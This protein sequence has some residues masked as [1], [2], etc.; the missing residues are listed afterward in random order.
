MA[1]ITL[2]NNSLSSVTALPAGVGGKVLQVVST[3]KT[4]TF[5]TTLASGA[6]TAITGLSASITPSS[7]SNKILIMVTL[8]VGGSGNVG[9]TFLLKRASTDILV[10]DT[11]GSRKRATFSSGKNITGYE[12]TVSAS[13]TG[14]DSPSTTSSTTYSVSI[15]NSRGESDSF[16]INRGSSDTDNS[17]QQR[18]ASTITL[19]EIAG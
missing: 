11:A 8:F 6:E 7:T 2:N 17:V 16:Y 1:I 4:D 14:L 13:F 12:D 18:T 10:G 9:T 3:A 5:S 15:F 19:L